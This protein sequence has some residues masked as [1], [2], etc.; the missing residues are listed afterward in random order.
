MEFEE[1]HKKQSS[2]SIQIATL[3]IRDQSRSNGLE[4]LTQDKSSKYYLDIKNK[5]L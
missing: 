5:V 4:K 3:A 2:K 1:N